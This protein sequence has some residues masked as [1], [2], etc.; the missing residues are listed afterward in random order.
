M[1]R[2]YTIS[3]LLY[4]PNLSSERSFYMQEAIDLGFLINVIQISE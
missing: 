1:M 4:K 3:F 2:L